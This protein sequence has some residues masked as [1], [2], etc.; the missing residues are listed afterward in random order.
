MVPGPCRA[1]FTESD[2]ATAQ[3]ATEDAEDE[4]DGESARAEA[5]TGL[6]PYVASAGRSEFVHELESLAQ[7][8]EGRG[9]RAMRTGRPHRNVE[10]NRVADG[11]AARIRH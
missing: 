4:R 3:V 8:V 5:G 11:I 9:R 7:F 6:R 1:S 2:N 10:V